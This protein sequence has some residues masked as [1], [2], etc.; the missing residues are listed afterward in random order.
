MLKPPRQGGGP[1][2]GVRPRPPAVLRAPYRR[3]WLLLVMT[4]TTVI[5][6][7][8]WIVQHDAESKADPAGPPPQSS[9]APSTAAVAP[10]ADRL[11]SV[12]GDG[13]VVVL[14]FDDGPHPEYTPRVLQLLARHQAVAT[15]CMV[16]TQVARHP[17]LVRQVAAAGMA[18]CA[19][20]LSHDEQLATR[21]LPV[22]D[23]EVSGSRSLLVAATRG[24]VAVD[25]FR[26][27]AGNWS[28]DLQLAAARHGLRS[29]SWSI[30]SRDWTKP[31][32]EQIVSLVQR[33]LRPGAIVLL[34]D[35]GGHREQTLAALEILL[36][37]LVA[38]GYRFAAPA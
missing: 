27:P 8:L 38:Q 17:D 15:F 22:I 3:R 1:V 34:H 37:W 35:G 24:E 28:E 7:A 23:A 16:G 31:G 18:L 21:P 2:A 6:L 25:Y 20:S 11:T 33:D 10:P 9:A 19:H 32:V 5:S 14:T 4:M 12:A 13:K 30:D 29:L 36:P 26:A